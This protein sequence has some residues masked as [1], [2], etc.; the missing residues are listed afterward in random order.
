MVLKCPL[1]SLLNLPAQ[2]TCKENVRK[3]DPAKRKSNL[4][5]LMEHGVEFGPGIQNALLKTIGPELS[6]EDFFDMIR[7]YKTETEGSQ[8][9]DPLQPKLRMCDF[10]DRETALLL[11][12]LSIH[13]R[14]IPLLSAGELQEDAV[15]SFCIHML[16]LSKEAA[17]HIQH[18][19]VTAT[20]LDEATEISKFFL[21]LSKPEV[22]QNPSVA[23]LDAVRGACA[24]ASL[25]VKCSIQQST[26][27]RNKEASYRETAIAELTVGPELNSMIEKVKKN[28]A[29]SIEE[30]LTKLPIFL[31][32]LRPERTS[33]LLTMIVEKLKANTC[34]SQDEWLGHASLCQK[35][36]EVLRDP[37]LAEIAKQATGHASKR[38][39][40]AQEASLKSL[41]QKFADVEAQRGLR[42][43]L[44]HRLVFDLLAILSNIRC[45]IDSSCSAFFP[46]SSQTTT[47]NSQSNPTK[48]K[49]CSLACVLLE[50]PVQGGDTRGIH[51]PVTKLS[52]KDQQST[53]RVKQ[54]IWVSP[55]VK[56]PSARMARELRLKTLG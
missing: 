30:S 19:P 24:G 36:A 50:I 3:M 2:E 44:L 40:E 25:L 39:A 33:P 23:M 12:R 15:V 22:V 49:H 17:E 4:K 47:H 37:S 27:W 45:E 53:G 48:A 31:N 5:R 18:R 42:E 6:T 51:C 20:A 21:V 8:Q 29:G 10:S 43:F 16:Q 52:P 13:E 56:P 55:L 28:E 14:L 41:L 34:T 26:F 54:V 11:V 35:A 7:P 46:F 9:F 38:A 32:Q 1:E